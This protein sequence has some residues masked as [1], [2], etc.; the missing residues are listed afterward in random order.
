MCTNC[1]AATANG[2]RTVGGVADMDRCAAWPRCCMSCVGTAGA[3]N[4]ASMNG[5]VNGEGACGVDSFPSAA[6]GGAI[7]MTRFNERTGLATKSGTRIGSNNLDAPAAA[8]AAKA[9]SGAACE[10]GHACCVRVAVRSADACPIVGAGA[11]ADVGSP[12][13]V[14]HTPALSRTLQPNITLSSRGG[15]DKIIRAGSNGANGS[16]FS[17]AGVRKLMRTRSA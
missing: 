10:S 12:S 17:N 11:A 7:R 14:A 2:S 3:R 4:V 6:G 9:A 5:V 13:S 8:D 1:H 15:G 16:V